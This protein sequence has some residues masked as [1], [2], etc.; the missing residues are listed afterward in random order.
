MDRWLCDGRLADGR[1]VDIGI[2]D[3]HIAAIEP[4]GTAAGAAAIDC[5]GHTVLPGAIDVHVHCREPGHPQKADFAETARAAAA[6]GVTT[7]VDQPNTD[8][9]TVTA[10]RVAQK[11]RRAADAVI[12]I[13][14]AGGVT[15]AW[16]PEGLLA[17]GIIALGEVFLADSTG[18]LGIDAALFETAVDAAATAGVPVTVHAEDATR[19]DPDALV[20]TAGA[21][22]AADAARW[23]RARPAAAEDAAVDAALAVAA[24]TDAQLH[25]AHCASPAAVDAVAATDATC[26]VTPHHL[27]LSHDDGPRLGTYGRMNP[28]LRPAADT[29]ALFERLVDGRIDMVASDHAPHTRAEKATTLTTAPSG[30]PGVETLLPLLLGQVTVGAIDLERVVAVTATAPAARFGLADRGRVAVGARADLVVVD[31]DS[32]APID[33]RMLHA[34][35][36][37][38]PF[39][40]HRGVFPELT[41]AAGS[42]VYRRR[43]DARRSGGVV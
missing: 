11:R 38:S 8:P 28:A 32:V 15:P 29:A 27:F 2:A 5:G 35:C 43:D 25:I 4:A 39:G 19:F 37:W 10:A 21:G 9:P 16:E 31:L 33:P 18:E 26:E 14:I 24:R 13:R 12:D 40:G 20:G 30:V 36:G 3:G 1:R 7:I 17:S 6:G 22:R 42:P 41:L 34:R 23:G